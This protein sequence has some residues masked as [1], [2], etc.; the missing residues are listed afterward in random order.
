M[1]KRSKPRVTVTVDPD[2][3]TAV[4]RYVDEHQ[5]AGADRS[6]VIDEALRLWC[7]KRLRQAL[8]EQYSAPRSEEELAEAADWTKIRAVALTKFGRRND[9]REGG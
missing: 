9:E 5:E 1:G 8:V 3:L 2:L 7:R 4:D 6:G